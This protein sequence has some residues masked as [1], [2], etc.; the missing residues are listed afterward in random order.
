MSAD[1]I[2]SLPEIH[3]FD[4]IHGRWTVANR[5][6]KQ[7]GVGADYLWHGW[8]PNSSSPWT[9]QPGQGRWRT[10]LR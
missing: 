7:W 10:T 5:R 8:L 9:R 6:L 3:D 2:D 1:P 4:F